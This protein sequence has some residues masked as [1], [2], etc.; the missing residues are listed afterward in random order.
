MFGSAAR[1]EEG[2]ESNLDLIVRFRQGLTFAKYMELQFL[3]EELLGH[4]V[5]L[6]TCKG[7]RAE[8]RPQVERGV[9]R[10]A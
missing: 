2:S 9:A 3:L 10:A 7:L 5:D 8:M 6:V 1:G 4:P